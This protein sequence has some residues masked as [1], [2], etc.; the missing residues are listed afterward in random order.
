MSLLH[1]A[2][3]RAGRVDDR[4]VD[5]CG[6]IHAVKPPAADHTMIS[7]GSGESSSSGGGGGSGGGVTILACVALL[8]F[9]CMAAAVGGARW[10]LLAVKEKANI[11]TH[12]FKQEP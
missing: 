11:P 12:K 1:P 3:A 4:A 5:G 9:A 6:A 10:S 7:S 2:A 8:L